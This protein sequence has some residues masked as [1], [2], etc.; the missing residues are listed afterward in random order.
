MKTIEL[1]DYKI[2][3]G[4]V[5]DSLNAFLK[6]KN[7]TKMCVLVDEHTRE[8]CLPLISDSLSENVLLL[9]IKSG[10]QYKCLPTCESIWAAMAAS[11]F[12]RHSLMINLGG[13]VIG[14]M[15]GFVASCYMRGIDFIQIPTTVL[16]QVDASVGGKLAVDFNGFKNFIGLFNNPK[17]VLIDPTF[18]DTLPPEEI[19]SGYAEMIKHGLINSAEIWNRL[20]ASL[21]Y[22][23]IDWPEE[24]HESVLVK[25]DVVES[26]PE[27]KGRRKILNFGHTI[28]HA[29]ES[30]ALTSDKPL[31]HGEAIGLGMIAESFLSR[32]LC[33]LSEDAVTEITAFLNPIYGKV[34]LDAL[35][36]MDKVLD[37]MKSDKKNK[38]GKILFALLED[39][40]KATHDIEATKEQIIGAITEL[41]GLLA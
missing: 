19:R 5:G 31:L 26:D 15:G 37:L 10:E 34:S 3:L 16:S 13:G 12:D 35:D 30:Y 38:G 21:D 40:G 20:K 18:I 14:D 6:D 39:I 17:T 22:K 8:H 27:E 2:L 28:G 4:P 41:K 23:K 33:G 25:K 24:I 7:Y 11:H 9:E 1:E 32:D 29:I 36:H